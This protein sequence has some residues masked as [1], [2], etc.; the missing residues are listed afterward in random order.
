MEGST[1]T[2]LLQFFKGLLV[3]GV[4][5]WRQKRRLRV[6]LMDARFPKGFR[7]TDQLMNA[8]AADR[9]HT[10]RLLLS[11]GARKSEISDE[12]TLS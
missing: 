9:M 8:I 10:E 7:S 6:M 4:Y 11:M 5:H 3:D 2:A 12:W 1:V